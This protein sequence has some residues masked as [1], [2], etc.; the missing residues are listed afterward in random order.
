[1][2]R[3]KEKDDEAGGE[4]LGHLA[5]RKRLWRDTNG[6]IVN[7]RR[8]YRQD[9]VKRQHLSSAEESTEMSDHLP[10][11]SSKN[12]TTAP[13]SP[14]TSILGAGNRGIEQYGGNGLLP[15]TWGVELNPVQPAWTYDSSDFLRNADWG[16]QQYQNEVTSSFDMPYDDIFKPDTGTFMGGSIWCR[17]EYLKSNK[18]S[19]V[20]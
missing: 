20:F 1:M 10:N 7:A 17:L 6:N 4:G 13:P 8:P 19:N 18:L 3:H 2:I 12:R 11:N 9:C 5:T 14:P 15:D 16:N